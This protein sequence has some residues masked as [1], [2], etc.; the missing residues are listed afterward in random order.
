MH[1]SLENHLVLIYNI[2]TVINEVIFYVSRNQYQK[3]PV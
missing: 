1:F 3:A 2:R